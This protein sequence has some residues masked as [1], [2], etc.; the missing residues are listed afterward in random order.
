M[1]NYVARLS[2]CIAMLLVLTWQNRSGSRKS[3]EHPQSALAL[4]HSDPGMQTL[5]GGCTGNG[6]TRSNSSIPIAIAAPRLS[7]LCISNP[8][9]GF[10]DCI[11][12]LLHY[13]TTCSPADFLVISDFSSLSPTRRHSWAARAHHAYLQAIGVRVLQK[14]ALAGRRICFR[15]LVRFRDNHLWR[16]LNFAVNLRAGPRFSFAV[17]HSEPLKRAA[18][19]SFRRSMLRHFG[20]DTAPWAR[21]ARTRVLVY[22]RGRARRRRWT[23][24]VQFIGAL[25][26][27]LGGGARIVHLGAMPRT[28]ADQVRLFNWATVLVAPHGGAMANTLFMRDNSAVIEIASRHCVDATTTRV[29]FDVATMKADPNSWTVWHTGYLALHLA[30]APCFSGVGRPERLDFRTH[31]RSLVA[32]TRLL[33]D[34]QATTA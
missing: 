31:T 29:A 17:P 24:A 30:H 18:L 1:G 22:D 26:Q 28:F 3:T 19:R 32:L 12:P 15:K 14:R 6:S 4:C 23:N 7:A 34:S 16:P 27:A 2:L 25:R 5:W 10:F 8:Y 11:W 13:L 21:D 9:H 33:I 20:L